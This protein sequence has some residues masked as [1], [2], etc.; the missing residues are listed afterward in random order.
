MD[1]FF[2][3]KKL[4]LS[5]WWSHPTDHQQVM[6][7]VGS[8]KFFLVAIFLNIELNWK[9]LGKIFFISSGLCHT[10]CMTSTDNKL[11]VNWVNIVLRVQQSSAVLHLMVLLPLAQLF[12]LR[13]Q[14]IWARVDPRCLFVFVQCRFYCIFWTVCATRRVVILH[15]TMCILNIEISW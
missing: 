8:I 1:M 7:D 14:E 15:C 13:L 3:L 5:K 6:K 2:A 10:V 4:V 11:A 12:I 9:H